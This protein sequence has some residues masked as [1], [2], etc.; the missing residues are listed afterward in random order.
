ML[1]TANEHAVGPI[2]ELSLTAVYL[3]PVHNDGT[4]QFVHF[5]AVVDSL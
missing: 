3:F 4:G 2:L 5:V 1:P